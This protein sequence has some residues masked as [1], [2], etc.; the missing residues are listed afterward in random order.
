M[1][2]DQLHAPAGARKP[3]RRLGRGHGSG[4]VKTSGR[5]QKGQK[6]RTGGQIPAYFEGGQNRF[7]QRTPYLSGFKN[8]F[9]KEYI[10]INLSDL[11]GFAANEAVTT[12]TLATH[13]LIRASQTKGMLKVL[14]EGALTQ[15]LNITAYKVS[16]SARQQIEAAGGTVTLLELRSYPKTK[17]SGRPAP[18]PPTGPRPSA[19][20]K[21]RAPRLVA[22]ESAGAS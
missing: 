10:V 5:G 20:A 9:R 8:P 2:L 4:R 19:P 17:R 1:R 21:R 7:S 15:P 3:Y 6:A 12:E 13:G 14:G 16:A 11:R 22:A 18:P